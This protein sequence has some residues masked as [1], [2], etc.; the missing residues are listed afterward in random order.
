MHGPCASIA[1]PMTGGYASEPIYS[2]PRSFP[3]P[4][5]SPFLG[6]RLA[7]G[8]IT[9]ACP[10]ATAGQEQCVNRFGISVSR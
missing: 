4:L 9:E 3:V 10:G 8:V 6:D 7:S 1:D 2:A 5:Q